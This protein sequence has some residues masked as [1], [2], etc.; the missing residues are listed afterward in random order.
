MQIDSVPQGQGHQ[1]VAAKLD[2]RCS[3]TFRSKDVRVVAEFD[4]AKD[5][6]SNA[7]GNYSSRFAASTLSAVQLA[8]D[9]TAPIASRGSLRGN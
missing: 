9:Q 8:A 6:W 3:G 5:A 4:T 2:E 1:T 7:A